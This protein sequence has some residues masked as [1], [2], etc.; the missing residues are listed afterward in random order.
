MSPYIPIFPLCDNCS[1]LKNPRLFL[2][3]T[4]KR[5][6]TETKHLFWL[7]K[8]L[9]VLGYSQVTVHVT[10]SGH[11]PWRPRNLVIREGH[12]LHHYLDSTFFS[13]MKMFYTKF[14]IK[15]HL[16]RLL[17][18]KCQKLSSEHWCILI[19]SKT[20]YGVES[21]KYN[22]SENSASHIVMQIAVNLLG[23]CMSVSLPRVP[24]ALSV[25]RIVAHK[26]GFLF[27][28]ACFSILLILKVVNA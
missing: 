28:N 26:T 6:C 18:L 21:I 7:L 12:C 16:F 24:D 25:F 19:F 23:T 11:L 4:S 10:L 1:L 9:D 15:R 20:S 13:L 22:V 27:V 5:P 17:Y 3:M 8:Q 2:G 14:S